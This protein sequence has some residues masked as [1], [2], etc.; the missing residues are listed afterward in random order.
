MTYFHISKF[1]EFH[2]S[3]LGKLSIQGIL[4]GC[5]HLF[6]IALIMLLIALIMN[7]FAFGSLPSDDAF[8]AL[9]PE[10]KAK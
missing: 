3:T 5:I 9:L 1:P 8:C 6:L 7:N 10:V 4:S 2:T